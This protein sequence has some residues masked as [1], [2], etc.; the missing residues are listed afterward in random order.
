MKATNPLLSTL[1]ACAV[2]LLVLAVPSA[3]SASHRMQIEVL[4]SRADLVSGGEVLVQIVVPS[5]VSA[6][7]V[8]ASLNGRD[9]TRKFAVR[10]DR[11]FYG[12][13]DGLR[14][15]ANLLVARL[16]GGSGAEIRIRNYPIGGPI[17]SGFQIQPWQCTTAS[18]GLGAATDAQCDARTKFSYMYMSSSP[19]KRALGFQPY[20]PASPPSNVAVTTTD[21]GKK[22]PYI[23]RVE[24][25]AQ[26]RG[27]YEI[28][29]LFDPHKPWTA[30]APQAAWNHKLLYEFG[31]SCGTVHSQSSPENVL[32]DMALSRG[33]MVAGSS[34]NVLGN[35]C[36]TVTSAEA[37]VMLKQRIIDRYGLIRYTIATGCSGGS[38]GQQVVANAY[39]GLLDGLMPQCVFP[40][41]WTTGLEVQDCHLLDH[42][43]DTASPQLWTDDAQRAAVDGHHDPS[44]CAAWDATFASVS[45]PT[46]GCGGPI[47]ADYNPVTNPTGCRATLQDFSLPILGKRPSYE[48][49]SHAEQVA[50]GFAK[51]PFDNVGVQYGLNALNSGKIS[52][53]QFIDLN[54]KIGGTDIDDNFVASR[55]VA[56]PGS[57][58]TLYTSG[59]V[60]DGRGLKGVPII[61]LQDW[62]ETNE[63]HTSFHSW[64][65]RARLD[66][67]NGNHNNQII[68]TY[69]AQSSIGGVAPDQFL[70]LKSF[71]LMDRW[72]SA[73]QADRSRVPLSAKVARDK[74]AGA[75]DAC[76]TAADSEITNT[77]TCRQMFPYYGD[78]RIAA[79]GPLSDDIA[80]CQLR[81]LNRST[82]SVTFTDAQ[83]AEMQQIFRSGVCDW[84]L[85]GVG[86]QPSHPW[87]TFAAGPGGRPLGPPPHSTPLKRAS[88][89]G[90]IAAAPAAP[91]PILNSR[92][93]GTG[94]YLAIPSRSSLLK[95]GSIVTPASADASV[96]VPLPARTL[97][98][99][100][101]TTEYPGRA[102]DSRKS[103]RSPSPRRAARPPQPVDGNPGRRAASCIRRFAGASE[104]HALPDCV[105][106]A[107]AR[108]SGKVRRRRGACLWVVCRGHVGSIDAPVFACGRDP[109]GAVGASCGESGS[110]VDH[111]KPGGSWRSWRR[112]GGAGDLAH[113]FS[114]QYELAKR[115]MPLPAGAAAAALGAGTVAALRALR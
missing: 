61:S 5:G 87:T 46:H 4:S 16:P 13:L 57:L 103:A 20:D 111:R 45:N 21:Q 74:P 10:S 8:R 100:M 37:V 108:P 53:A 104:R 72:L 7:R 22:V 24:E 102:A 97:H 47:S 62:S 65:M 49:T 28:A 33:F 42:Y 77:S 99:R 115:R 9:V 81:P 84:Q 43:F 15:G 1:A 107:A 41:T 50:H 106:I 60:N 44:D 19:A 55:S 113:R 82:Y 90:R 39:P 76:F 25:G 75:V 27:I 85:P 14:N 30:W 66:R 26:D 58:T 6:R 23:V 2:V 88:T 83:W 31:P 51:S 73:M 95:P 17:F 69:P 109:D 70:T 32:D 105:W 71:L 64:E 67:D 63:I 40:D 110:R 35:N 3:A 96:R 48:W 59:Q 98:V 92:R 91:T 11:R 78:A 89:P 114:P 54:R 68:W 12:L 38:I 36:N 56:D 34:M 86:Q 18:N 93:D 94:G 52:V 101:L 29:V 112:G 80:E 79:G